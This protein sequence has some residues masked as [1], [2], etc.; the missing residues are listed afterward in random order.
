MYKGD[1]K[2]LSAGSAGSQQVTANVTSVNGSETAREITSTTVLTQPTEKV[3]AV[4]TR[5][6]PPGCPR[7]ISSGPFPA[8]SPPVTVTA[9]SSVLQL[10]PGTGRRVPYGT[11]V[12]ASDGGTVTYAGW[13]GTYGKLVIIDHGDGRQTYYAHNSSLLVNVGDKVYQGQTIAR[14]GSTGRSTGSHCHFEVHVNGSLVNPYNYL[15]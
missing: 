5:S 14:A 10:P 1:S 11:S 12:V 7:A 6:A 13:Q 4:G 3:V 8:A 9:L 2:V 15:P